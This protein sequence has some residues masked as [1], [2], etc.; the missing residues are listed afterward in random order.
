MSGVFRLRHLG[1][2]P[3]RI[4][5]PSAFTLVTNDSGT[6]TAV[7]LDGTVDGS[8]IIQDTAFEYTSSQPVTGRARRGSSSTY[9]KTA[10]IVGD[11][12]SDGFNEDVFMIKDE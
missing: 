3:R 8:G 5:F 12:T 1:Y 2:R 9:Y 10:A 4:K 6:S 11:I 7:I